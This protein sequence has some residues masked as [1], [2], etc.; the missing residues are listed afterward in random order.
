MVQEC[1]LYEETHFLILYDFK[2]FLLHLQINFIIY[3]ATYMT[4][5]S[6]VVVG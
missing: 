2:A 5:A 3:S 6:S 4:G 1:K